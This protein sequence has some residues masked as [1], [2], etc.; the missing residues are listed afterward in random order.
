MV[1]CIPESGE[2]RD[3][4]CCRC[5]VPCSPLCWSGDIP[6]DENE[7]GS[8]SFI[9][10]DLVDKLVET[11]Q[12][13][14]TQDDGSRPHD[15]GDHPDEVH[16]DVAGHVPGDA[17]DHPQPLHAQHH[18]TPDSQH[19]RH[20]RNIAVDLSSIKVERL[21]EKLGKL[22]IKLYNFAG[23]SMQ[24]CSFI[25]SSSIYIRLYF[26]VKYAQTFVK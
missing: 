20:D 10:T 11:H 4:A 8:N 1:R 25:V 14:N 24:H 26:Y 16:P 15:D 19:T 9:N 2:S 21:I 22:M 13:R 5:L 7:V 3:T 18:D 6:D 23:K 12:R 17:V